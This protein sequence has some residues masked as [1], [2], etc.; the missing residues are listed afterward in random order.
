MKNGKLLETEKPKV[1]RPQRVLQQLQELGEPEKYWTRMQLA[2]RL[3][4]EGFPVTTNSMN[5]LCAPAV[6]KGPKPAAM[7]GRVHLYTLDEG[8]RWAEAR[9]TRPADESR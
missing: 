2:L 7:W 3:Q 9:L 6:N 4:Q 8:M 5:R 1:P